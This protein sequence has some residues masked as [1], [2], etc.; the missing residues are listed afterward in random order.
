MSNFLS[1]TIS[2]IIL[3]AIVIL[4]VYVFPTWVF[5]LAATIFVAC[6]LMEFFRMVNK[7]DIFVYKYF[8]TIAGSLIPIVIYLGYYFPKFTNLEPMLI[9]AAGIVTLVLQ[10]LRKEADHD[11]L[12]STAVTVFSILYI[13]WFFSFMV[14]LRLLDNGANLVAY[15][16]LVTKSTDIGAYLIGSRIGRSEL[17]PRISPKKTKEGTIGG[18]AVSILLSMTLGKM[19]TGFAY[20]HLFFLGFSLAVLGQIGDLAESLLKR[21]CRVKDSAS[22]VVGIGGIFDVIDSLLFTAPIFYFYVKGF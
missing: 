21:D 18:V 4:V 11:H 15:L 12:V 6:G 9:V 2:S 22:Y 14:K 8:G 19:L 7:R 17:I 20:S 3:A 10:F 5:C 13:A 16:I 1:R